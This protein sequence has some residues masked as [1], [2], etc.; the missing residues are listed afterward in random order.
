MS[1]NPIDS[2]TNLSALDRVTAMPEDLL[3]TSHVRT[4]TG[5]SS[6]RIAALDFTKGMLVLFM[7]LYHWI[8][9]FHGPDDSIL[10][11]LRFL[12]PSFIF[13]TGFLISS[14]Y[15]AKYDLT[16]PRLPKRLVSRGLKVLGIFVSL[17]VAITFLFLGFRNLNVVN[18]IAV[19]VTG[20]VFV[21]GVGKAAAFFILVPISYLLF[22]SAVLLIAC[23]FYKHTFYVVSALFLVATFVLNANGFESAN[24][25]LVTIGLLGLIVGYTSI[26]KINSFVRR[27]YL[28]AAMYLCYTVA[29]SLWE[30]NYAL[31]IIGV[32]LTLMLI[33]LL[34]TSH[35]EPA[36][37]PGRV[38][39]LGRYPLFG[40]IAQIAI[41]QVL[42]RAVPHFNLGVPWLALTFVI[43]L[44]LTLV[45][46]IAVDRARSKSLA[47]DRLY[48]SIFA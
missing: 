27:P 24:L 1:I 35:A 15:L 30:P 28:L 3:H 10:R 48:R 33:Y 46:V 20:N 11:Y 5:N 34:G 26:D 32:C 22:L 6:N 18:L 38:I 8:C 12:P 13:I 44:A 31:Q 43:G 40:Y 23:R 19:F 17:N 29:I 16:D 7:V 14:A 39:L 36:G 4:V 37:I 25:E 47:V 41:L 42:R 9:Y 21:S 2:P 45:V